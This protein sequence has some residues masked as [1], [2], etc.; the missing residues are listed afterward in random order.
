MKE[1]KNTTSRNKIAAWFGKVTDSMSSG[2]KMAISFAVVAIT[3]VLFWVCIFAAQTQP[4]DKFSLKNATKMTGELKEEGNQSVF[5]CVLPQ[6]FENGKSV[7]FKSSHASVEVLLDG[8]VIYTFGTEKPVVGK[9]PGTCWHVVDVPEDSAG[10]EFVINR[11]SV[12]S[13]YSGSDAD[14]YF[15]SRGDCILKLVNNFIYVLIMNFVSIVL[16]LICLL[17]YLRTVKRKEIQA[18]S[19]FLWIG[20]FA[21]IV[22]IWSLRQS[23]FLRFLIP[24]SQVLYFIDIH[25]LFLAAIPLDMFVGSISSTNWGKSCRWFIPLYLFGVVFG[26]LMQVVGAFDLRQMLTVLHVL[27]GINAGYMFWAIHRE[28][29]KNKGSA[30]SRFRMPLYTIIVFGV[31]EIIHYYTPWRTTSVFLPTGVMVFILMLVWQQVSAYFHRLEEQKLM[32]YEKFANTDMLTGALNRNAYETKLKQLISGETELNGYG[33]ALF[34]LNNLKLIN[35]N[36]G[37]EQGDDAIRRCYNYIVTAFG[38][39]GNCYRIGGDEFVFLGLNGADIEQK[40]E[41]FNSLVA[42]DR[43]ELEYPFSVASGYAVY[44]AER[45]VNVHDTIKRSDAMM[46]MDKKERKQQESDAEDN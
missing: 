2:K 12:Y 42:R 5:S 33:V 9:S 40:L 38:D 18:G 19:G 36:F 30:A 17:L 25:T 15:G 8:E 46:Y 29:W 37:H 28:A 45:D 10:C 43:E 20:L 41:H 34:D 4:L 39:K 7:L 21:I 6:E 1:G 16:G 27:I 26:T 13:T 35:D 3:I 23:G 31:M 44:D 22:A 24:Y 14:F 32:Y 11:T